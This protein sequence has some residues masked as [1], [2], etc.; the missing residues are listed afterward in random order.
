MSNDRDLPVGQ[1]DYGTVRHIPECPEDPDRPS[2]DRWKESCQGF[3]RGEGDERRPSPFKMAKS[4]RNGRYQHLMFL[5]ICGFVICNHC[6]KEILLVD[7]WPT[8]FSYWSRV[9]LVQEMITVGGR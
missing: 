4:F 6:D 8:Y 3:L 2:R 9:N 5:G 1:A 7:P